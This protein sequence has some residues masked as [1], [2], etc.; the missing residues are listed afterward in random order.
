MINF[1]N[2][3][4]MISTETVRTMQGPISSEML[5]ANKA[6]PEMQPNGLH[7][8]DFDDRPL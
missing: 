8:E 2:E 6:K 5:K 1:F 7:K 4:G 3:Y